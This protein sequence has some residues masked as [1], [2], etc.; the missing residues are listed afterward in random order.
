[1]ISKHATNYSTQNRKEL[2]QKQTQRP[3]ALYRKPRIKSAGVLSTDCCST[4]VSKIHCGEKTA[5]PG[6]SLGEIGKLHCKR[7]K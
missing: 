4:V 1:M 3:I 5:S 7:I 6:N 2:R